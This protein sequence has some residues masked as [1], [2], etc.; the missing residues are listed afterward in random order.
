MLRR[1]ARHCGS[2][3]GPGHAHASGGDPRLALAPQ[4][5]DRR[6][7]VL[8]RVAAERLVLV[9]TGGSDWIGGSG[10]ALKVDSGYRITAR[11]VFSSASPV[12]DLLM[13]G[14]ILRGEMAKPTK[15]CIFAVPLASPHVE[16][17]DTWHNPG[18]ARVR[19]A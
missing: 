5:R 12:G 9:S 8:K 19:F 18:H 14:A 13:T 6:R 15:C 16:I 7:A 10:E 17:L 2:R 11:K 1:L 4:G 3:T